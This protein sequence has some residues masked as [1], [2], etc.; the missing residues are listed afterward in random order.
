MN[1]ANILASPAAALLLKWTGLLLLAWCAHALLRRRDARWRLILW[2]NLLCFSLLLPLSLCVELP[3]LKVPLVTN[4]ANPAD[5]LTQPAPVATANQTFILASAPAAPK[6]TTPVQSA[7]PAASALGNGASFTR[8]S[9]KEILAVAWAF[10]SVLG[11]VRLTWLHRALARLRNQAALPS[12]QIGQLTAQVR[13]ALKLRRDIQIRISGA[14]TSPFVCGLLRPTIMLPQS[15]VQSLTPAELRAVLNHEIAHV[16]QN[17]LIWCVAWQWLRAICWF[18]PLVWLVPVA[19]NL[20]CEQEADRVASAQMPELESYGQLLAR[21][22]LKVLALP[23]VETRLAVNGGSQIAKRLNWLGR[24]R[25]SRW[26][27]WCAAAAFSVSFLLFFAVV[28]CGTST[29][30]LASTAGP[31]KVEMRQ[32]LV[33]VQDEDGKPIAGAT[34]SPEGFRVKGIHGADAYTWRKDLFGPPEKV[35]TDAD[36]KAYLKYPVIGIPEEKEYTGQLFFTVTHPDYATARPQEYSVDTPEKP[37]RLTRGIRLKVSGYVGSD[38]QSVPE[39]VPFLNEEVIHT[40]DWQKTDGNAYTFSQTTPGN[41]L[42]RLMG[43]L[44]SGQIVYSDVQEFFA[45]KGK[46]YNFDLEM[47]PGI[48]VEGHLDANVPRPVTNG[49]VIIGVRSREF[50]AWTNWNQIDAIFKRFPNVPGWRSYRLIASDGTFVFESVPPGELDVIVHGDGFASKNGGTYARNFGVPQPFPLTVPVTRI[51]VATEPTATLEFTGK[52]KAGKPIA[53]AW[54]GLNPN[55]IRI[56]GGL[57]GDMRSSSEEPF[58]HLAPLPDVV[59]SAKTGEDGIAV[60]RNVPACTGGLGFDHPQY[61]VPLQEPKGWRDRHVR[62][63]FQAGETN[64]LTMILE[65]KGTDYIGTAR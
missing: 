60:I 61:Q 62:L 27:G 56:G 58:N 6:V 3:G 10:G 20:A 26:N 8:I 2:R 42:V 18:H 17:D 28:G 14:I 7:K 52:T 5:D 40:N 59:Y 57:F 49:R 13:T 38:R 9:W 22:A 37:I 36:G 65:P 47:K 30:A 29:D 41:H 44:P 16:R 33:V 23:A 25:V 53:G 39:L 51:E 55:V 12:A 31:A 35:V 63:S 32:V 50:P 4:T 21:L 24:G 64:H 54:V 1:L 43:R 11:I 19:H 48:R 45:E 46:D 34:I 15:L